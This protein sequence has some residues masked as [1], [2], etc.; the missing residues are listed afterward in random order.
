MA[1]KT[2][3]RAIA[4]TTKNLRRAIAK[5]TKTMRT[6]HACLLNPDADEPHLASAAY[7][8]SKR[9]VLHAL[10]KLRPYARSKAIAYADV[11]RRT[12]RIMTELKASPFDDVAQLA[13]FVQ[14]EWAGHRS[15]KKPDYAPVR[16]ARPKTADVS[17]EMLSENSEYVLVPAAVTFSSADV[18]RM[19]DEADRVSWTPNPMNAKYNL[20][21]KQATWGAHYTFGKQKPQFMGP[22]QD[23]PSLVQICLRDAQRRAKAYA[24]H[25]TGAH[26]NWYSSGAAGIA[27]HQDSDSDGF[28]IYSYTVIRGTPD[29]RPFVISS[30]QQ[31]TK[32]VRR[33]DLRSG[34][35]LIM[36]GARFQNDWWHSVPPKKQKAYTSQE[37]I[38]ITIRP[39]KNKTTVHDK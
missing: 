7:A 6:N 14:A 4:K 10:Q 13:D 5:T 15:V 27:P 33:I 32:D 26:V 1:R 28:P 23:A 19:F 31:Q 18:S 9:K 11:P 30:D 34:D 8:N 2:Q 22:V 3:R 39:W 37:R 12:T 24:A 16:Q 38:N 25:Y 17:R 36:Q 21:R 35:L 20:L 29:S